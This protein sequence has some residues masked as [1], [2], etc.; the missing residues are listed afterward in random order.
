MSAQSAP[1]AQRR[2]SSG[3]RPDEDASPPW[4]IFAQPS[5]RSQLGSQKPPHLLSHESRAD[6][7]LPEFSAS[8]VTP[9]TRDKT[10]GSD[11]A[12][13]F[14]GRGFCPVPSLSHDDTRTSTHPLQYPPAEPLASSSYFGTAANVMV[15]Q[16]LR[17]QQMHLSGST[18]DECLHRLSQLSSKLLMD[19]G[20]ASSSNIGDMMPFPS[21]PTGTPTWHQDATSGAATSYLSSTVSKLFESLQVFLETVE[22]LRPCPNSSAASECSYSE[23]WDEPEFVHIHG[24]SDTHQSLAESASAPPP[25]AP[26]PFDMPATLTI[27]TCYIWL[28]KGYEMVL[29][30]IQETLA[31]QDRLHGLKSLPSIFHGPGIGSFALEEHPDMQIEIVIHI[32][33]QLLHRIEGVLGIHVVSERRSIQ[34]HQA[35]GNEILDTNSAAALLDIWFAKGGNEENN[36]GDPYGGRR[37][38]IKRN[39]E[40]IRTL[41]RKYWRDFRGK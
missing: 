25:D 15:S 38:L 5:S 19:F 8:L 41:L 2:K 37:V 11:H 4:P 12:S 9:P 7:R 14:E 39:V 27:L 6:H 10:Q 21:L 30:G 40:N 29:S 36:S 22:R 17:E 20:K 28:L 31:S 26:R 35:D 18:T 23:Q 16:S 13:S 32:G 34:D 3:P 24:S 33:S 1:Q